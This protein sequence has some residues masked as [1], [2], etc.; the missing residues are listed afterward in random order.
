MFLNSRYSETTE[1]L[2]SDSPTYSSLFASSTAICQIFPTYSVQKQTEKY[3][4]TG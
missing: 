3:K 4:C 1:D 2:S